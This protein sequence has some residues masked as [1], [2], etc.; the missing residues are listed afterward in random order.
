MLGG[1][2]RLQMKA[3]G[4]GLKM[5]SNRPSEH[6]VI[7]LKKSSQAAHPVP[8]VPLSSFRACRICRAVSSSSTRG[9]F[10]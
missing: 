3:K 6:P 9:R 10:L 1:I 4:G 7:A 2:K 8:F 5:G